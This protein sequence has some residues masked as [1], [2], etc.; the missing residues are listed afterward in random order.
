MTADNLST[1]VAR[2]VRA[3]RF[4]DLPGE[5]VDATKR[6]LLD[7]VGVTLAASGLGE[8]CGAFAGIAREAE[9][10]AGASVI[11]HGFRAPPG[12]AAF[13]N[14][15]MAHALDYED[16][17]DPAL[18]HPNAAVVPAALALAET[19]RADGR[20]LLTAIALGCDLACRIALA[21]EGHDRKQAGG[22]SV[23][24][25]GGAFGA[26]AAAGM[27]LD[28]SEEE[29]KQALAGT[30]FQAAFTSEAFSH[31]PSHMRGVREAFAARAGVVAAQLAKG[32]VVAFDQPFEARHG[33]FGLHTAGGF[34][35]DVL[36]GGLGR[37]FHG[38]AV[39]FKPWPSC[40]GTHAFIEAAL[41]LREAHGI[42]PDRVAS[43]HAT[44]S[45][46]FAGLCE[47]AP[48][49]RRPETAIGAK[50]S[51]PFTVAAALRAGRLDLAS[52]L[53]DALRDGATLALADR[54]DHEVEPA[55]PTAEAT[56]GR[57]AIRMADDAEFVRQV[58]VPLGHPD[59]PMSD[60]ALREK[61]LACAAYARIPIAPAEAG[62]IAAALLSA[63]TMPDMS[64]LFAR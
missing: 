49:K 61:F 35:R 28:L 17:F 27:L 15:A 52:F 60:M 59:R 16:T 9:A 4:E 53:P 6:S 22:F 18:V 8:A 55:W 13:A 51:L 64:A 21:V 58:D 14:G 47:P 5:V 43:V 12:L 56:R 31:P 20:R 37:T 44:V 24:F 63:E 57:L 46:F 25:M 2:H 33:L 23:R 19:G 30:L 40:R 1:L 50:L 34:E 54:I 48:R 45:P 11:G 29:L 41:G 26:A 42:D 39:S 62:R 36:L 7:A 38:G 10:P 3:A 32:G